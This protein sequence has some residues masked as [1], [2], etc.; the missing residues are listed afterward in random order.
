VGISINGETRTEAA[1]G[2]GPVEASFQAI[3]RIVGTD[4]KM[5]D[6]NLQAKGSGEDA[7]GQVDIIAEHQGRRY[8]G[9]GLATDIVRSSVLAYVHVLN[10]IERSK[11]V[12]A[13]KQARRLSESQAE[14]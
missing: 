3:Q 13:A 9:A 8:H 12:D 5:V 14:K 7:L 11:Q 1:T 2:N 10:L 6:F 4:V